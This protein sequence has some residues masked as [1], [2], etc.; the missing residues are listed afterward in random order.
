MGSIFS[1]L[2]RITMNKN[3]VT[4]FAVLAGIIVLWIGYSYRIGQSTK[5]VEVWAAAATINP[6]T[7]ID[8]SMLEKA[9]ISEAL[10]KRLKL[11][12]TTD[13]LVDKYTNVN[14][15]IPKSGFFYKENN[16]IV[17]KEN[18]QNSIWQDLEEDYGIFYMKVDST[19]TYGNSILPGT[20]ID[21]YLKTTDPNTKKL[22][23]KKYVERIQVL[24]VRDSAGKNVFAQDPPL[25][26][27]LM[28]FA[29]KND[30][31]EELSYVRELS[32]F[33]LY[34]VPR[35]TEY[36]QDGGDI[37]VNSEM[38]QLIYNKIANEE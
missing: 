33:E 28:L 14:V 10:A 13:K 23:F 35:G 9:K 30:L 26:P 8:G 3:T 7:K 36:G 17:D 27:S 29:V 31:F 11:Y 19:K 32:G 24:E 37:K 16:Q 22:I 2:K 20:Y 18:V 5:A 12:Y 15:T 34:P 21:L 1:G 4:I 25:S 38:T 6:V